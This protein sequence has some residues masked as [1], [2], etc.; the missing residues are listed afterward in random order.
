MRT[1]RMRVSVAATLIAVLGLA[2]GAWAFA[3]A[4][5]HSLRERLVADL[6]TEAEALARRAADPDALRTLVDAR[7]TERLLRVSR[8]DGTLLAASRHAVRQSADLERI[9]IHADPG[10]PP[11]GPGWVTGTSD[12]AKLGAGWLIHQES[13]AVRVLIAAPLADVQQAVGTVTTIAVLAVP[14]LAAGIWVLVWLALGRSLRPVDR[15]RR[16]AAEAADSYPPPRLEATSAG[17]ELETLIATLDDLL[18]RSAAGVRRQRRF[19]ADAA[20]ELLSPLATL[21]TTLEVAARRNDPADLPRVL[22]RSLRAQGRLEHTAEQLLTIARAEDAGGGQPADLDLAALLREAGT[23]LAATGEIP[24]RTRAPDSLL[25]TGDEDGLRRLVDNLL[26]NAVRHAGS[27]VDLHLHA[28]RDTAVL[29]VDDDGPG[30]APANRRAVFE[31]FVRLDEAR[32]R[33]DGG[34]GLGL[35]IVYAIATQHGGEVTVTDSP[36][37]GARFLV[38]LPRG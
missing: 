2:L 35:A 28:T 26:R 3:A 33:K 37:G 31:P 18:Q 9:D 7:T 5:E 13:G 25:V 22:A 8:P 23:D 16:Q 12:F 30:I 11:P 32:A 10:T 4:T 1:L 17:T 29:E 6:A 24:V 36:L 19:L 14:L 21:R 27:R 34:T 38:R 20:H 15:L